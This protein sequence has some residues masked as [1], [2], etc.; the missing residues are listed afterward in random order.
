M[1]C[2]DCPYPQELPIASRESWLLFTLSLGRRVKNKARGALKCQPNYIG[3]YR[4]LFI[5]INT[6]AQHLDT[7]LPVH[8]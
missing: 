3:T 8:R 7:S 5:W 2:N 4:D 6:L 1:V